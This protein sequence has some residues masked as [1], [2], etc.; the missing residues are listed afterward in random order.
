MTTCQ[1]L[2]LKILSIMMQKIGAISTRW[3]IKL[4]LIKSKELQ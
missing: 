1:I 2:C 4:Q 3:K